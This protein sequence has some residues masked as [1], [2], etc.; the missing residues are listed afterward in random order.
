MSRSGYSVEGILRGDPLQLESQSI[1]NGRNETTNGS[2]SC[3]SLVPTIRVPTLG[4]VERDQSSKSD[5]RLVASLRAVPIDALYATTPDNGMPTRNK[6][7]RGSFV[8]L[9][10]SDTFSSTTRFTQRSV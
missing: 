5:V 7:Q 4:D 6:L 1:N 8:S 9:L 3:G 10:F 2:T